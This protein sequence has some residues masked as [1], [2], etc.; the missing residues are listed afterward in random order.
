MLEQF[1]YILLVICMIFCAYRAMRATSVLAATIWL[2]S[3]SMLAATLMFLIGAKQVA[4]IELS[5]GAG[6]VTVM[7]VYAISVVGDDAIDLPS[8]IPKPFAMIICIIIAIFLA[9]MSLPFIGQPSVADNALAVAEPLSETLWQ[10]RVL[11]VW[12]QIVLIFC[13]V[14]G[15]LGLLTEGKSKQRS[16]LQSLVEVMGRDLIAE[17]TF[18]PPVVQDD[19][20]AIIAD[21]DSSPEKIDRE[22]EK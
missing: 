2:A 4:V 8:I 1:F 6:L 3:V 20:E 19:E 10:H 9:L 18:Q 14:L 21:I 7:L 16:G 15:V 11:D 12:V 17:Q 13:G 5:V 22:A